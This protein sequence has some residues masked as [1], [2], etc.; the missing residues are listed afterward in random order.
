M[1]LNLDSPYKAI[2]NKYG[3]DDV[4]DKK[5][6]VNK[7]IVIRIKSLASRNRTNDR[8]ISNYLLQSTALPTELSRVILFFEKLIFKQLLHTNY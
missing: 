1:I 7:N 4:C 5:K 2:I 8:W 3:I 6:G